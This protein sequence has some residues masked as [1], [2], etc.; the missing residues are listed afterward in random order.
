[1]WYIHKQREERDKYIYQQKLCFH[2]L[3]KHDGFFHRLIFSQK[4][5]IWRKRQKHKLTARLLMHTLP[6][7]KIYKTTLSYL[8]R[9]SRWVW[10]YIQIFFSCRE[11]SS[12]AFNSINCI[13][14]SLDS[15]EKPPRKP[16]VGLND[17]RWCRQVPWFHMF[18]YLAAYL[19]QDEFG[20][21]QKCQVSS[22]ACNDRIFRFSSERPFDDQFACRQHSHLLHCLTRTT[23]N[24]ESCQLKRH[25]QSKQEKKEG[26]WTPTTVGFSSALVT[27][28]GL[29]YF[30]RPVNVLSGSCINKN[31]VIW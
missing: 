19:V 6:H 2:Q 16:K 21:H 13:F 1:M 14:A 9:I 8:C 10:I 4:L 11:I 22:N 3:K 26:V 28:K 7:K 5:M 25:R 15:R 27:H 17:D 29:L 30:S 23:E 31:S 24:I 20:V 18:N 12:R